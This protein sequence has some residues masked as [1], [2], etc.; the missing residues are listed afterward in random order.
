M[1]LALSLLACLAFSSLLLPADG[2]KPANGNETHWAFK[3]PIRPP[4]PAVRDHLWPRNAIDH[5][6]L[7]RLESEG[8]TPSAEA[9]RVTLIRR[10]SLD[11]I[12][13]P[14]TI[15]EV[16]AFVADRSRRCL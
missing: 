14:P 5:F 15:A 11:L 6:V 4:V 13:L 9:D 8:L 7:A 3:P 10:L 16:D 1:R 2:P 12:G